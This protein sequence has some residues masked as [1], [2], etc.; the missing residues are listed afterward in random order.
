LLTLG[1]TKLSITTLSITIL[2]IIVF[3][4]SINNVILIIPTLSVTKKM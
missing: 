1:A 4:I 3:I 2:S